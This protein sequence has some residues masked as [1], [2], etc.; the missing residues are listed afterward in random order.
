MGGSSTDP[1]ATFM[2]MKEDAML[3]GQHNP[4]YNVQISTEN[5]FITN[6][7]IYQRPTDTLTMISNLISSLYIED[8]ADNFRDTVLGE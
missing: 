3:N 1:D 2:R 6:F 5:R 7:G 4:G 8:T